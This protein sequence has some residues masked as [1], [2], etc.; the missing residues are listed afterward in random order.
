LALTAFV[1][2]GQVGLR[3]VLRYSLGTAQLEIRLFGRTLIRIPFDRILEIRKLP[4]ANP[5]TDLVGVSVWRSGRATKLSMA[6]R[7]VWKS[8]L[9]I[10]RRGSLF[11]RI[12]ITPDDPDTYLQAFA[13]WR[14]SGLAATSPVKA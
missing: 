10:R 1:L 6:N 3:R 7:M 5:L 12:L 13:A 9:L 4:S 8:A 2:L 11:G 14:A